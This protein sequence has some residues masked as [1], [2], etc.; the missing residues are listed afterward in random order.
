MSLFMAQ[1]LHKFS[2]YSFIYSFTFTYGAIA[3]KKLIH[4]SLIALTLTT[5]LANANGSLSADEIVAQDKLSYACKVMLG[6]GS[7][8][9]CGDEEM[10]QT[11]AKA[12]I[13]D[14]AYAEKSSYACNTMAARGSEMFCQKEKDATFSNISSN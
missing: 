3:M 7:S 5:G 1:N 13:T 10:A 2:K 12:A 4:T 6:R 11:Y 9:F 8:M 14:L